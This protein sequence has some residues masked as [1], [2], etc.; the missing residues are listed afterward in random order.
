MVLNEGNRIARSAREA[1]RLAAQARTTAR[2]RGAQA[3]LRAAAKLEELAVR[4]QKVAEQIDRRAA[5]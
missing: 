3:K 5:G 2:F 4:C 1:Q